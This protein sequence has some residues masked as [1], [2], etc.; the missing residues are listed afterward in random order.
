MGNGRGIQPDRGGGGT[1]AD[2]YA[3]FN[4]KG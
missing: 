3:F 4:H 2:G 1:P